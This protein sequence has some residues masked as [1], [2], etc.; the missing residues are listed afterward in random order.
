MNWVFNKGC[1]KHIKKKQSPISNK[2]ILKV[3]IEKILA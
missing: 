2:I 1:R 3:K